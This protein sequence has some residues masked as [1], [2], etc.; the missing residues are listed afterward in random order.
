MATSPVSLEKKTVRD[1]PLAGKTVLVRVDF[2][3]PIEDGVVQDAT[4]L[5]AALPTLRLLIER[6]ARVVLCSHLG[7]PGGRRNPGLSLRPVAAHVARLLGQPVSFCADAI[8]PRARRAVDA[9]APGDVVLLENLRFYPEEERNA[10]EFAR[11]L[12][13]LAEIYV[14]DAFGAAHRAHASTVGVPACLLGVAGLLM[15][16]ELVALQRLLVPERP[17]AAIIGG[18]KV[19]DKMGVLSSLSDRVEKLFIGGGMANTFLRALGHSVGKSLVEPDRVEDAA[20]LIAHCRDRGIELY[21]PIDVVVGD[22]F[23]EEANHQVVSADA[24]P[25]HWIVMDVGPLTVDRFARALD[26]VRTLFWNGPLGVTEWPNFAGGTEAM[27]KAVAASRAY[28]V[29]GGGDSAAALARAGLS[30][31][32]DHVSTGGGASLE[33]I[34]GRVLPGVAALAD[35]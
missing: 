10:P 4:R 23:V 12:A 18:A 24:V 5:V 28:R 11:A 33:F 31:R 7:R 35:R 17:F 6:G 16:S 1:V 32:V 15:E 3:V 26:G 14:D 22:F 19:S 21:L 30:D 27:A 25:A 29:V 8:G 20:R 9:L 13:S 2:N 34:E